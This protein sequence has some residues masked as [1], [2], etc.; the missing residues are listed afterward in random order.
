M[1]TR[2]EREEILLR[3]GTSFDAIIDAI[4]ANIKAKNQ[5][6][7]TVTNLGKVERLEEAFESASRKLKRAV[8]L[9]KRTKEKVKELQQQADLASRALESLKLAEDKALDEIRCHHAPVAEPISDDLDSLKDIEIV[10]MSDF[11][12]NSST[13]LETDAA[14][15]VSGFTLG[16]STTASVLEMEKFYRE[17]ELEMFGDMELPNM[18]GET[19]ELSGVEIP[20]E[21]R[22]YNDPPSVAGGSVDDGSFLVN[23]PEMHMQIHDMPVEQNGPFRPWV[24]QEISM[25]SPSLDN[26]NVHPHVQRPANDSFEAT[27][28]RSYPPHFTQYMQGRDQAQA[29]YHVSD[30]KL[31]SSL[32]TAAI[33]QMMGHQALRSMYE[34]EQQWANGYGHRAPPPPRDGK[35]KRRRSKHRVSNDGP[36]IRHI[37]LPTN[38]TPTQW[39]EDSDTPRHH[40]GYEPIT[41]TE[42]SY[43]RKRHSSRRYHHPYQKQGYQHSYTPPTQFPSS[44]Y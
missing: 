12:R 10:Q 17:L 28:Y 24:D 25:L 27:P 19:L 36:Q 7:Q 40:R 30:A 14:S 6:R 43:E 32:D 9:R 13:E 5:R 44:F 42:D 39:M 37:P 16:N 38:L 15:A 18:V 34:L 23:Y 29:N 8:L 3:W 22:V 2:D 41:I 1:L 26:L 4:R 31:R 35:S 11:R 20:E 33:N 21:E